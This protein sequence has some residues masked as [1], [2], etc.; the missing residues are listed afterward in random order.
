[1]NRHERRKLAAINAEQPKR[2]K[3]WLAI[4]S[5]GDGVTVIT[6][7]SVMHD[8][9][10]LVQRGDQVRMFNELGH[11]D[12]YQLR[13]Q[14]VSHALCDPDMTDLVFI[15]SDVGWGPGALVQL[16]DH[17]EDFVAGA[18][19][20]RQYPITFMFRSEGGPL[21]ADTGSGLA[22]VW[23]MPGGFMRIK[24][25]VLEQMDAHYADDLAVA[26]KMVPSGRTVR[27]FDPYWLKDAEGNHLRDERGLKKVLAEDYAFCQ[28]WRD[29]GGQVYLDV[30]IPM[31]HAGPHVFA[32]CL[33]HWLTAEKQEE[34]AA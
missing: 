29:L 19:P 27:M 3:I 23:G 30:N 13:A 34:K 26:D 8:M 32:G 16:I 14:I 22:E 1:M 12:I 6:M 20:K 5:Y 24:R 31:A 33:G 7:K 4:P 15:D 11:A 2:R 28:R 9:H 17:E 21:M 25:H 18:Y 10:H